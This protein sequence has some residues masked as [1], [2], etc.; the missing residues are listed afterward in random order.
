MKVGGLAEQAL[1]EVCKINGSVLEGKDDSS[2]V[3]EE[4]PSVKS[5]DAVHVT[6]G[7]KR[8]GVHDIGDLVEDDDVSGKRV[9]TASTVA[10]E[11]SKESSR[12][13]TSVQNVSPIGLKSSR[14]DEDTGPVQQLVA[15]FGALVA[16]GEKAVGSLGIL[17]SSIS[18]DL[19][20]EVVMANMRHIPPE[21][22][23]DEGEEESLLNMGSNAVQLGVILRPNKS[24]GE[25]EHHVA[26]VADSDLACG[27]MDCGTEQGM[28]SAG[29]PISSNVLPSAIENFSA[30]SYEIHDVG[31]LESIPGLD[32]T[33]HDDRFVET[34]A[35]SSLA[36]ADL[37]EG[38]QEQVTSLGRRS[39]LDLLPSM[40]T[41]RSEELSP[42]SSL[43]DANSIIS[44]TETSAGLSSQFVLPKLLAPVIDLT[45]EQKDLIQKLAY[46]RIVDAYKQIAVAGGSH[47]RFSLLAYLG[48]QVAILAYRI[49]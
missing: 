43:T 15:M 12:D 17:I 5:C 2:I 19:L 32:S 10:E 33:A 24:Q 48:V 44:S 35:A 14:G 22:P 25:E 38:S 21:R 41:D 37:E 23:K 40:S 4:K 49:D 13:L 30:T 3:K 11:P 46:A 47:V 42:K 36:S 1:R 18:T 31:N 6:L 20:A 45:D 27:D 8:S 39:Q 16:Q 34:L 7:R 28:D 26:T 9:R 29:V